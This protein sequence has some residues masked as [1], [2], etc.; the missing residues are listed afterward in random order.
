[1]RKIDQSQENPL[2]NWLISICDYVCPVFRYLNFTPND[3]TTLSLITGLLSVYFL[4]RGR[5]WAFVVLFFLSY[6][7]DCLDGHFARKYNMVTKFGDM[8]DHIKD[9]V[10]SGLVLIVAI[11][12]N[13]RCSTTPEL[14][15]SILVLCIVST[16]TAIHIRCQEKIYNGDGDPSDEQSKSLEAMNSWLPESFC[17]GTTDEAESMIRW[18]RFFGCGTTIVTILLLVVYMEKIRAPCSV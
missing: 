18:T 16:G 4:A 1:M 17:P 14:L 8:Y 3:I 9:V 6:F 10:V 11:Y 12:R 7:F 5:V 15:V 2:D 13:Y